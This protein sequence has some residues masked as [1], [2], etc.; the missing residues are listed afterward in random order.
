MSQCY[1]NYY[2]IVEKFNEVMSSYLT[3]L[4][5]YPTLKIDFFLDNVYKFERSE[6]GTRSSCFT[7]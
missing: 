7:L 4:K 6:I 1:Y 2:Y 3:F 5:C